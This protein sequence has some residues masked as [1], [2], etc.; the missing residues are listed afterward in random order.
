VFAHRVSLDARDAARGGEE[1]RW[2]LEEILDAV[3]VPL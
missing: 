1:T 2:V 3:P